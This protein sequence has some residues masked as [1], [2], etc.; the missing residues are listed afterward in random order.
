MKKYILFCL[1]LAFSLTTPLAQA[2][3]D[4]MPQKIVIESR[5]R[6]GEFTILNLFNTKNTFRISLVNYRQDEH[7]VYTT[8]DTPLN[9]VFDPKKIVRF[10]PRQF[11]IAKGGRQKVRISVRKPADLPEGE[12]RF[13]IQALS[14]IEDDEPRLSGNNVSL[15]MNM[16]VTIPV[17][18]RHGNV[19]ATAKLGTPIIMNASQT[20]SRK[21]ELHMP[22]T[23]GGNASAIGKLE[24]LWQPSGGAVRRIGRISN[25]NIFSEVT[26]RYIKL[27]LYEKPSGSGQLII[28]YTEAGKKGKVFDEI[29]VQR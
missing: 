4:I 7:G 22:I 27:P 3:I 25:L 15:T 11:S 2:R 24:V 26:T 5:Q 14:F 8:L 19:S 9:P 1:L 6:G 16:G 20:N 13:H 28:R 17:V 10:S 21:P 18:V 12:Y 29:T 23:R